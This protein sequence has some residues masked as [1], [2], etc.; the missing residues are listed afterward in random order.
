M[1]AVFR[2]SRKRERRTFPFFRLWICV[3]FRKV[4]FRDS[5]KSFGPAPFPGSGK[6]VSFPIKRGR[7]S[8]FKG[9][10][11]R[12]GSR[13]RGRKRSFHRNV[14]IF[15]WGEF[16]GRRRDRK[17][18]ST[19]YPPQHTRSE[20]IEDEEAYL[21]D[22]FKEEDEKFIRE[23]DASIA[24][25]KICC[26]AGALIFAAGVIGSGFYRFKSKVFMLLLFSA[27]RRC[28]CFSPL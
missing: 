20:E 26:A 19:F 28:W 27:G 9:V 13:G 12:V 22:F 21:R 2:F 3:P 11:F 10:F 4:K 6:R 8:L 17:G 18:G 14:R 1:G 23:R 24:R 5:K 16:Y 7:R 15:Q 25:D